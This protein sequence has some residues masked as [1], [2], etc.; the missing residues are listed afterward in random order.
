MNDVDKLYKKFF[1]ENDV[2]EN[3]LLLPYKKRL[4][5]LL[6]ENLPNLVLL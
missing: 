2:K 3:E 5:Q 1:L 6:Q 4:K